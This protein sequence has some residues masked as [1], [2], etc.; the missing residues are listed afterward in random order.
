[1]CYVLVISPD[2]NIQTMSQKS[3]SSRIM[4]NYISNHSKLS[5]TLWML[6]NKTVVQGCWCIMSRDIEAS[7]QNKSLQQWY[8]MM[9]GPFRI[10]CVSLM[11]CVN[12]FPFVFFSWRSSPIWPMRRTS[13]PSSESFRCIPRLE[14]ITEEGLYFFLYVTSPLC[15]V[16]NHL[17][18]FLAD[19]H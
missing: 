13:P 3:W 10:V 6:P 11:N 17:F 2:L 7:V 18:F 12:L 15:S 5:E 1:M 16:S 4:L 9:I 14:Q 19:L 8:F